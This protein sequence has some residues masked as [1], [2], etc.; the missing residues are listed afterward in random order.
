MKKIVVTLFAITILSLSGC[1]GGG[2]TMKQTIQIASPVFG[3]GEF[4]PIKYTG[5]GEDVSIPLE[6]NDIPDK[7]QSIAIIMDDPDAPFG[8]FT[9]WIIFDI[10][11]NKHFLSEGVPQ[12]P[13]LEDGSKQGRNDFGNIG[14]N[15][16][17]PPSGKVHH[18][19][20]KIY[21]LDTILNLQPGITSK[22]FF[23]AIKGHILAEGELIGLFK[24]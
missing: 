20:I 6:W 14:Y 13:I 5:F 16:P 10:S 11:K 24:R 7:T 15:G 4:I 18:Y 8:T 1:K 22:A 2:Y 3:N 12:K 21:A 17:K 19:H 9:H 23:R